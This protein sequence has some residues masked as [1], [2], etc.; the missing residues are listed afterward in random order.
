MSKPKQNQ[1]PKFFNETEEGIETTLKTELLFID[2]EKKG[3]LYF[4]GMNMESC[5]R[6]WMKAAL[7]QYSKD[8]PNQQLT[9]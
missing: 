3:R 1:Q 8:T 6:K 5:E 9:I 2:F 4:D 7:S